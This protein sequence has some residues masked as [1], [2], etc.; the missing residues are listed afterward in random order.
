MKILISQVTQISSGEQSGL[1]ANK[2]PL[3]PV[4]CN[5]QMQWEIVHKCG[6]I[7][8]GNMQVTV[9]LKFTSEGVVECGHGVT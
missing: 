6:I 3:Q 5:A 9:F 2:L 1:H 7:V 4:S 8:G